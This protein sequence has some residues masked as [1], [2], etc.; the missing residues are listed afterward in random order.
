MTTILQPEQI[1]WR[2][3]N[4]GSSE[5][6]TVYG[7]Y[8]HKYLAV[9]LP[10]FGDLTSDKAIED[11][12]K[13]EDDPSA[14]LD[15]AMQHITATHEM[16]HF[17]DCFGT[18]AGALLFLNHIDRLRSFIDVCKQLSEDKIPFRLPLDVWV[19]EPECPDYVQKFYRRVR[20]NTFRRGI[21]EGAFEI[22]PKSGSDDRIWEDFIVPPGARVPAFPLHIGFE[23]RDGTELPDASELSN[24]RVYWIPLGFDTLV[25]G[26]AQALQH[27]LLKSMWP[28]DVVEKFEA[29]Q[30]EA[31]SILPGDA[32]VDIDVLSDTLRQPYRITDLLLSKYLKT[33][34]GMNKFPRAWI[35][36][37]TDCALMGGYLDQFEGAGEDHLP[38]GMFVTLLGRTKWPK[39]IDEPLVLETISPEHFKGFRD[40]MLNCSKPETIKI[41]SSAY[42]VLGYISSYVRHR[43][44]TP[45]FDL[46]MKYG[47]EVFFEGEKYLKHFQEFPQPPMVLI[48]GGYRRHADAD[49]DF[50]LW[51]SRY[52]MV[53]EVAEQSG[54][55][56]ALSAV[57][58]HIHR[59]MASPPLIWLARQGAMH[60]SLN[61]VAAHGTRGE[62][63][64][65]PSAI[66]S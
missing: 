15:I 20:A 21:F 4:L 35:P 38:G 55:D 56:A 33:Q 19:R 49:A 61:C 52:V 30:T 2:R 53:S 9:H 16:R 8:I 23:I 3:N 59:S 18:F 28:E 12:L 5:G 54:R 42:S 40:E 22:A 66:S 36:Q 51:W 47:N 44:I 65:C 11:F 29:A 57:H 6:G 24:V 1:T 10:E 64:R 34:Q 60:R 31:A 39:L 58:E 46:R 13:N 37:L 32:V 27:D 7:M 62:P 50:P 25:E 43:I 48:D 17:H 63:L 45:L 41:S 26:N 14:R